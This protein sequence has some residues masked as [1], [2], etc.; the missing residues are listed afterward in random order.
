MA[1]KRICPGMLIALSP[2]WLMQTAPAD[3]PKGPYVG[4]EGGVAW[5]GPL[6][7]QPFYYNCAI[8]YPCALNYNSINFDVGYAAG[9]QAG[10][11]F[12]GP[13]VEFEYNYRNNSAD[14]IAGPSGTQAAAGSLTSNNFMVNVFYDFDTGSRWTPYAGFGLG[15]SDVSANTIKPSG[16]VGPGSLIDGASSKFSAQFIFG[17]EYAVSD[18]FGVM[19][20]WRG[21]WASSVSYKYGIG[22]PGGGTTNC[23]QTG[24]TTYDYWNGALNIGL[25]VR[26]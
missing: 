13:R 6:T 11:A 15:L 19:L 24:T 17:I 18:R 3:V 8:L 22:C 16:G 9:V 5:T 12:G 10:Y 20:D 25:H 7:F 26:F 14:T 4:I 23:A 2:F 21:L 1:S